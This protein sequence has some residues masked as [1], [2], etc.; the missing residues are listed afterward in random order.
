MPRWDDRQQSK[1]A[2]ALVPTSAIGLIAASHQNESRQPDRCRL[3]AR[4]MY[5]GRNCCTVQLDNR[6]PL[7]VNGSRSTPRGVNLDELDVAET[8]LARPAQHHPGA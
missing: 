3:S 6:P 7:A 1:H 2:S 5:P 8:I 4:V